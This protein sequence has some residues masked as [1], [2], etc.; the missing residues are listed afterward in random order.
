MPG[1][2]ADGCE[3][4]VSPFEIATQSWHTFDMVYKRDPRPAVADR[5]RPCGAT[6]AL[7]YEPKNMIDLNWK[8]MLL[9]TIDRAKYPAQIDQL[10]DQLYEYETPEGGWPYPFDK[11][12][13]PADFIS[14]NAVL[15]VADGRPPAGNR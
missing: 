12:A 9:S 2:E 15:A 4:D 10:I 14:Y 1:D 13:K 6:L 8:I 11:K 5:A 7:A 3:P